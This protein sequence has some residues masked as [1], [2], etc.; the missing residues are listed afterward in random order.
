MANSKKNEVKIT[1]KIEGDAWK[2]AQDEVFKKRQ[3]EV[4][5]D[6][7]RPGKVPRNIYEKKFGK[8]SLYLDAADKVLGDAFEAAMAES[9]AEPDRKSVM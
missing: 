4:K 7:F 8:E 3:K 9:K 2:K 1:K 6:G 5:V